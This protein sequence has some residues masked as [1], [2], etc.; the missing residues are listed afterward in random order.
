MVKSYLVPTH[1]S[2]E[3]LPH[4]DKAGKGNIDLRPIYT[5]ALRYVQIL[6]RRVRVD[7]RK[8]RTFL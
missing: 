1:R 7:V 5:S 4:G 2:I 3:K 8:R 6:G